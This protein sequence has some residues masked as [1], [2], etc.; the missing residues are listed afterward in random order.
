[1]LRDFPRGKWPVLDM[2]KKLDSLV[3]C[4]V[5]IIIV[6]KVDSVAAT[7]RKVELTLWTDLNDT[8][9]PSTSGLFNSR[10]HGYDILS[11]INRISSLLEID[12]NTDN[13]T[14][15]L[16]NCSVRLDGSLPLAKVACICYERQDWPQQIYDCAHSVER[17]QGDIMAAIM[18]QSAWRDAILFTNIKTSSLTVGQLDR[19]KR[20]NLDCSTSIF[21]LT[22]ILQTYYTIDDY[23]NIMIDCDDDITA[24]IMQQIKTAKA[25][26]KETLK[27]S[28]YLLTT[29]GTFMHIGNL[30]HLVIDGDNVGVVWYERTVY[31]KVKLTEVM[32]QSRH[33]K[34]PEPA[35]RIE[36]C[37][38]DCNKR[39]D[40]MFVGV[41]CSPDQILNR[42]DRIVSAVFQQFYGRKIIVAGGDYPPYYLEPVD[43]K[44]DGGMGYEIVRLL[45]KHFNYSLEVVPPV[46]HKWGS[47]GSDGKWNGMVGMVL[48]GKADFCLGGITI[49]KERASA[50]DFT[51]PHHEETNAVLI[52]LPWKRWG[53][54]Y[55]VFNKNV[56][57]AVVCLPL[58][59][60]I[61]LWLFERFFIYLSIDDKKDAFEDM[62]FQCYGV[63][64]FQGA[65]LSLKR[66]SV[67]LVFFCFWLTVIITMATYT[68]NLTASLAVRKVNMP[69]TTLREIAK[70]DDYTLAIKPGS[71][72]EALFQ[73]SRKGST[74]EALWQKIQKTPSKSFVKG[75]ADAIARM[76]KDPSILYTADKTAIR[77]R[78]ILTGS[79][80]FVL[81]PEEYFPSGFGIGMRKGSPQIKHFNKL[82]RRMMEMGLTKF[83]ENKYEVKDLCGD[84]TQASA[85]GSAIAVED[86]FWLFVILASGVTI[87][88]VVLIVECCA[89]AV[90][91]KR[92]T[93]KKNSNIETMN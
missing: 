78:M 39:P 22:N 14:M 72:R 23:Y 17:H 31:S 36:R 64:M 20:L 53:F 59:P 16:I 68:G 66:L 24:S 58:I 46:D 77:N 90:R 25:E 56:W 86:S 83:W 76:T 71:I 41:Y 93:R 45:G 54:F 89:M 75:S 55:E 13:F 6:G 73:S 62:L 7:P 80:S 43:N 42:D 10:Q 87:S 63:I 92:Q 26:A 70:R 44:S 47:V 49:S 27:R 19:T 30:S 5:V 35:F 79:C 81:L 38:S 1:M 3:S 18:R 65:N 51:T 4:F 33:L 91:R 88:L 21:D 60:T 57:L 82:I 34:G 61:V 12:P 9:L 69:F 37:M 50:I 48:Y 28:N 52:N 15:L 84:L 32:F 29:K 67:R 8:V 40:Y 2:L 74:Y 11:T 85:S